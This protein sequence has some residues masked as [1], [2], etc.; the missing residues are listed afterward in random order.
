MRETLQLQPDHTGAILA[1]GQI[2]LAQGKYDEALDC[3]NTALALNDLLPEGYF[4]RGLLFEVNR[5]S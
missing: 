5:Q 1:D 2:R 4:L 3:Y